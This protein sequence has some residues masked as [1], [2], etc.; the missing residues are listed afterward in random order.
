MTIISTAK[1]VS[2]E[3]ALDIA[4]ERAYAAKTPAFPPVTD[5]IVW[6]KQVDWADVR[7]RARAGVHTVGLGLA[8]VG[9]Q[10]HG[11]GACLGNG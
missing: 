6:F 7:Q 10:G 11:F 3:E 8:V 9:E 4:E 5:T 1:P 2:L